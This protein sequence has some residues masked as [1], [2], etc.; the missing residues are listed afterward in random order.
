MLSGEGTGTWTLAETLVTVAGCTLACG[1]LHAAAERAV[2]RRGWKGVPH[3]LAQHVVA[4]PA[5]ALMGVAY[6][7]ALLRAGTGVEAR[8]FE[9]SRAHW[10]GMCVNLGVSLYEMVLYVAHG[11]PLVVWLHHVAVSSALT[12]VLITGQQAHY[13]AWIGL[14]ELSNIPLAAV[15]LMQAADR[16]AHPLYTV[17]GAALWL[18]FLC[19]RVGSLGW[20]VVRLV[21]D[22]LYALP[23][24]GRELHFMSR[25][26]S[27][28]GTF[29]LWALSCAWFV[30]ISKGL[31]K[32][33]GVDVGRGRRRGRDE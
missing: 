7:L 28:L 11:K 16:R 21:N 26:G 1:A 17:A 31:L 29:F 22:A 13:I 14:A 25:W 23:A 10:C 24:I 15:M 9:A 2:V 33:L 20:A 12:S 3:E 30:P 27:V 4:V 19:V 32:A 6:M 5:A 8:N 18:S